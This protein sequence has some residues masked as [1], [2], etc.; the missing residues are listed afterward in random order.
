MKIILFTLGLISLTP[1][2]LFAQSPIYSAEL[3]L[4]KAEAVFQSNQLDSAHQI[5]DRIEKYGT[6]PFFPDSLFIKTALIRTDVYLKQGK[7][8]E[9]I[10]QLKEL[11]QDFYSTK[12]DNFLIQILLRKAK[13]HMYDRKLE[14]ALSEINNSLSLIEELKQNSYRYE[15][16][17]TLGNIRLREYKTEDAIKSFEMA[18]QHTTKLNEQAAVFNN[19]S[20]CY[21]DLRNFEQ[22][23]A[24]LYKS[25]EIDRSL[26]GEFSFQIKN[27]YFN[28]GHIYQEKTDYRQA[29]KNYK[30]SLDIYQAYDNAHYYKYENFRRLGQ[31]Y[32]KIGMDDSV[33]YY[34]SSGIRELEKN[35]KKNALLLAQFQNSY[36]QYYQN[37]GKYKLAVEKF[38]W[39][40]RTA[41]KE[42]G[43]KHSWI[44]T[45]LRNKAISEIQ[46]GSILA[47]KKT[48][49]KGLELMG[50]NGREDKLNTSKGINMLF[51]MLADAS[52][53][54]LTAYDHNTDLSE[55]DTA[56]QF[57]KDAYLLNEQLIYSVD[58]QNAK[59]A[60][61]N[62][63]RQLQVY[64]LE[65]A[66][67]QYQDDP[68]ENT[69]YEC[70]K[71]SEL[72]K[73]SIVQERI[74][75]KKIKI[76]PNVP[77]EIIAKETNLKVHINAM[78]D[79]IGQ[80]NES[81]SNYR[82]A[83]L[84]LFRLKGQLFEC[85]DS[86]E[87]NYPKYYNYTYS[88]KIPNLAGLKKQLSEGKMLVE[89]LDDNLFIYVFGI[90]SDTC[91]LNRVPL[92]DTLKN[93]LAQTVTHSANVD[94]ILNN[95][96]HS[97]EVFKRASSYVYKH[98]I[99]NLL[100]SLN[101]KHMIIIPDGLEAYFPFEILITKGS[102]PKSVNYL[103]NQFN[104]SYAQSV[105]TYLEQVN[106]SS[107]RSKQSFA[108]FAPTFNKISVA[109]RKYAELFRS[110]KEFNLPGAELEVKEI[111][112]ITGGDLFLAEQASKENIL[113]H[114]RSYKIL[115]LST[116]ALLNP[117]DP[118]KSVILL[119]QEKDSLSSN[120]WSAEEISL[121]DLNAELVVL[122]A[123]RTGLGLHNS[124]EGV[125]SIGRAFSLAGIPSTVMS[126]WKVPDNTT[127]DLMP[128][129]YNGLKN[130]LNKSQAL[131]NAKLRYLEK[132]QI[133][134]QRHP[135]Y[136][137]GFVVYG[138][139]QPLQFNNSWTNFAWTLAFFGG[140][141]VCWILWK[142]IVKK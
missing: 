126:L 84:E 77:Q 18:L 103:L 32:Q 24:Y 26:F 134:E 45:Y 65:C 142:F 139:I 117:N 107:S 4:K 37:I 63:L 25:F 106:I 14:M 50:Y 75:G 64:A 141:F 51:N 113:E 83:N 12:K 118:T 76:F 21:A 110:N 81:D 101:G 127:A 131:R 114:G 109:P 8:V 66:Y 140:I 62:E 44:S 15:Y 99:E 121:S 27:V 31:C 94:S 102:N 130:K 55:I 68:N 49:K 72:S 2:P 29:I 124:S 90:T 22:A 97:F 129:F 13:V 111:Q 61:R 53:V 60:L 34:L 125:M 100:S 67:L 123:C 7:N 98:L 135:Y 71:W 112:K 70:F 119:Q 17:N 116:H 46:L 122:S 39:A 35:P 6:E 47:A 33:H 36:G 78:E 86:L 11:K 20:N 38:D 5:L 16:Y 74:R 91:I 89:F 87:R 52:L 40:Y 41:V 138:N 3:L 57:I 93:Y 85:I 30:I 96:T 73:K 104:I 56:Y 128:E 82:Q 1:W 69:A 19:I 92:T 9:A 137:A 136:W 42:I 54:Y 108:G 88:S 105:S 23:L 79:K 59:I 58:D 133:K 95:I 120:E 132:T 80:L 10:Q 48:I 43:P 28:F 115:H